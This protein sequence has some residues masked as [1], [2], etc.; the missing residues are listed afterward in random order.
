[1]SYRQLSQERDLSGFVTT[2]VDQTGAMVV[3]SFKGSKTPVLCKSEAD[4]L[5]YF[6]NPSATYP[7]VFE[8]IAF[9]RAA[10][11]YISSAIHSDAL[12]GGIDVAISGVVSFVAGRDITT[13]DFTSYPDLSHVFFASSP[14]ADDIVGKIDYITGKQF[15]LTIYRV[16]ST[17]NQYITDYTYSLTNEKDA[18][19]A[20]LY[21]FDVFDNVAI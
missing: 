17:G 3:K 9:T 6:G 5:K 12:Y 4:V 10:P 7:D 16:G 13:F 2:S 21:I 14:Y 1:M 19:G 15:K 11:C 8:A 20:S 18:F